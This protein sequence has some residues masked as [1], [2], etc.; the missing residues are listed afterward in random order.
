[1]MPCVPRDYR[2]P[3]RCV[4]SLAWSRPRRHH[5]PPPGRRRGRQ[6]IE[7]DARGGRRITKEG[8]QDLDR[9][10]RQVHLDQHA[11]EEEED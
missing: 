6:V 10:A 3:L 11:D 9:I 7:V 8:Q 2:W 4:H 1:L 5:L